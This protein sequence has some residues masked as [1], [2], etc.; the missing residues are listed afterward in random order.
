M[1]QKANVSLGDIAR[2]LGVSVTTVPLMSWPVTVTTSV[3]MSPPTPLN[4]PGNEQE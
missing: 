1:L 2:E 4:T 3:W